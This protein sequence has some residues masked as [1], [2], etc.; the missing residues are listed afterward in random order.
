M[1]DPS[2]EPRVPSGGED[3][4]DLPEPAPIRRLRILVNVLTMVLIVSVVVVTVLLVIRLSGRGADVARPSLPERIAVPADAVV[5]AVGRGAPD[6][7]LV[8]LR[9]ADGTRV[10]VSYDA[11]TGAEL[12]RSLLGVEA[13]GENGLTPP[14]PDSN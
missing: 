5:E 11:Q 10:L 3:F 4:D 7:V 9:L 8:S 12:D 6:E 2:A 14:S 1:S 13:G